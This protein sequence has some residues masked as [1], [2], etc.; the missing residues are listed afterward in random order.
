MSV[1]FLFF[2]FIL[3]AG[4]ANNL[5]G[6]GTIIEFR[7]LKSTLKKS[8]K[9]GKLIRRSNKRSNQ[10]PLSLPKGGG[11]ILPLF[12]KK[13]TYL[14]T[15]KV[16][17]WNTIQNKQSSKNKKKKQKQKQNK[18][19]TN[20]FNPLSLL[21]GGVDTPPFRNSGIKLPFP[22][23]IPPCNCDQS[24]LFFF[25]EGGFFFFFF[26]RCSDDYNRLAFVLKKRGVRFATRF[27]QKKNL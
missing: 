12:A 7:N 9:S 13:R 15:Y 8:K 17:Q 6:E 24:T 26:C 22:R 11:L 3:V 5:T 21:K 16:L 2:V 18:V 19:E 10:P 14:S 23:R 1:K 25:L 4:V 20:F 27:Q